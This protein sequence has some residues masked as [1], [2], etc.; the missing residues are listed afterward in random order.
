[1]KIFDKEDKEVENYYT[2]KEIEEKYG[3]KARTI[4]VYLYRGQVFE[5]KDLAKMK[6]SRGGIG[7]VIW[8]VKKKAVDEK[9]KNKKKEVM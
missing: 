7:G 9:Y 5:E 3:I 1:M 8:L 2:C 6:N 4:Q